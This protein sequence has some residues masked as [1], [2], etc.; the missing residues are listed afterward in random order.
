MSG[1]WFRQKAEECRRAADDTCRTNEARA[2]ARYQQRLWLQIADQ[3]DEK[4]KDL[5]K[6]ARQ[7]DP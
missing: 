6:Q 7:Q 2:E 5:A 4:D 3:D 1:S